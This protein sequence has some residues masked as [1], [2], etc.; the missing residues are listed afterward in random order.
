[1]GVQT[2]TGNQARAAML[3]MLAVNNR[4]EVEGWIRAA[5]NCRD[6]HVDDDGDV[7]IA[8]PQS[9]HMLSDDKLVELV[10]TINAGV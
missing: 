6:A 4:E 2:M 8:E 7:T 9:R 1:M 5:L 10:T 3:D